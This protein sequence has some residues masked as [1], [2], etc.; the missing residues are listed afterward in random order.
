MN[1]EDVNYDAN[2]IKEEE[3]NNNKEG[4]SLLPNGMMMKGDNCVNAVN[5]RIVRIGKDDSG[6]RM[7]RIFIRSST[8]R[9][10]AYLSFSLENISLGDIRQYDTVNVT[11]HWIAYKFHNARWEDRRRDPYIQYLVADSVTLSRTRMDEVY[12]IKGGFYY[13]RPM[14]MEELLRSPFVRNLT[15]DCTDRFYQ[16]VAATNL[17]ASFKPCY[18]LQDLDSVL[19]ARAVIEWGR[20]IRLL[21][22]NEPMQ[23][24][25][26]DSVRVDGPARILDEGSDLIPVLQEASAKISADHGNCDFRAKLNQRCLHGQLTW[27]AEDPA[28]EKTAYILNLT[29][30]DVIPSEKGSGGSGRS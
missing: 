17:L 26:R 5:G 25:M 19:F 29:N 23:K 21:R 13:S 9:K 14:P 16:A 10:P 3:T 22:L 27:L 18:N 15:D 20:E 4:D 8:T 7:I 24:L 12:G 2:S 11:G 28:R 1:R 6:R 30:F